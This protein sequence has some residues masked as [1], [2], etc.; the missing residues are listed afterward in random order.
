MRTVKRFGSRRRS[1]SSLPVLAAV[2]LASAIATQSPESG[3]VEEPTYGI[4]FHAIGA[5]GGSQRNGCL[6]VAGS[7]GPVAPGASGVSAGVE[8]YSLYAGFWSAASAV[9]PDT[10][11][12][13]GFEEC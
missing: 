9:S 1:G 7:V 13:N 12:L 11:F 5:I 2:A 3:A 4:D 8:V 6:V 10:V